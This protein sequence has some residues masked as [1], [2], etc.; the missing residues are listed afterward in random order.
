M[1][2][3]NWRTRAEQ[4]IFWAS[5]AE[6]PARRMAQLVERAQRQ[7]RHAV[8]HLRELGKLASPVRSKIKD[9]HNG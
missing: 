6:Q 3:P 9:H 8:Q 4:A 7:A 5:R 2:P 1:N